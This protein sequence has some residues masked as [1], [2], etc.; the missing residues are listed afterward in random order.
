EVEGPNRI[1]DNVDENEAPTDRGSRWHKKSENQWKRNIRKRKRASVQSYVSSRGKNVDAREPKQRCSDKCREK[2]SSFTDKERRVICSS[3]WNLGSDV[4]Q[5]D[6]LISHVVQRETKRKT[7]EA[8]SSR[9]K[10]TRVFYLKKNN[11]KV[12]VCKTFFMSTLNIGHSPIDT[13]LLHSSNGVYSNPNTQMIRIPHNKTPKEQLEQVR[14][15]IEKIPKMES[16]YCRRD[17][18]RQYTE[19]VNWTKVV[20]FKYK[21]SKPG[22]I[23]V[24]SNFDEEYRIIDIRY[25]TGRP[26]KLSFA[27][28]QK[29]YTHHLPIST[30]K[31]EDLLSLCKAT[32]THD[33]LIP[34]DFHQFYSD[35]PVSARS[36]NVAGE[37]SNLSE[38]DDDE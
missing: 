15:H 34:S 32:E 16:H 9:R 35:L 24:K 20:A 25:S 2:C 17:S 8:S 19:I 1:A 10:F 31:K 28:L 11:D 38:S 12:R 29:A 21:K 14:A 27:L 18:K 4:R 7:T 5:K 22:T 33:S 30:A 36:K 13:A 3:F 26:L 6:F 37:P 23:Q